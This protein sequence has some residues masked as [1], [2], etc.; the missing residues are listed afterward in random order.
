MIYTV[1]LL[2]TFFKCELLKNNASTKDDYVTELEHRF[3]MK[4]KV[5]VMGKDPM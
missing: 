1:R 5:R 3:R 4:G 2:C